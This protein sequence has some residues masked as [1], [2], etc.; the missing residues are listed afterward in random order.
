MILVFI[1]IYNVMFFSYFLLEITTP[2]QDIQ[3]RSIQKVPSTK[4][5]V[6]NVA[7]SLKIKQHDGDEKKLSQLVKKKL[8][9][10]YR[11]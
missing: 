5:A 3:T 2:V 10:L 7:K 1:L 8:N 11:K 9:A 4:K 6:L